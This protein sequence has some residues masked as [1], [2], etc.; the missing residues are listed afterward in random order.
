MSG[1]EPPQMKATQREMMEAKIPLAWRDYCADRLIPL[2]ECRSANWW[3]PW[4]CKHEKHV[5]EKCQYKEYMR[6]VKKM[7]LMR[8]EAYMTP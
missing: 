7:E 3:L 4:T 6:R 1:L 8:G 2:N 5:Y